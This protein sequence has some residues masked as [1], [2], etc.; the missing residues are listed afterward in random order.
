ML[1]NT[2][3]GGGTVGS[4]A[5]SGNIALS[6]LDLPFGVSGGSLWVFEVTLKGFDVAD[7]IASMK[8]SPSFGGSVEQGF[9]S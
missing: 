9:P 3:D 6:T 4:F 2:Y 8:I 7:M 1:C 5:S